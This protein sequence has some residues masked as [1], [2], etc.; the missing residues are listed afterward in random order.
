M[1]QIHRWGTILDTDHTDGTDS[2]TRAFVSLVSFCKNS[3]RRLALMRVRRAKPLECA[4][5]SSAVA[6]LRRMDRAPVLRSSTAEGGQRRRRFGSSPADGAKRRAHAGH[7]RGIQ[8]GVALRFPS[9]CRSLGA[10]RPHSKRSRAFPS[11]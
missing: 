5:P 9:A 2:R 6:L 1:R 3:L 10:G 7:V 11:V 4:G 8:S